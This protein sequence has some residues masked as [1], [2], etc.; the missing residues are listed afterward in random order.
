M[1]RDQG[2]HRRGRAAR[3]QRELGNFL[4]TGRLPALLGVIGALVLLYGFLFSDD[5]LIAS[6]EVRGV[7]LG[8]SAEVAQVAGA[9]GESIFRIDAGHAAQRIAAL[10]YV[11][12]VTVETKFPD[13]VV[14]AVRERVPVLVWQTD[15]ER[16]LVDGQGFVIGPGQSTTLPTLKVQNGVTE[17]SESHDASI[18]AS[19]LAI[20]DDLGPGLQ[21]LSLTAESGFVAALTNGRTVV[22]GD[23]SETPLKL[24]ILSEV[25]QLQESWSLLDLREP[26]R[27]YYK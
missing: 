9:L 6:V 10:T 3:A 2:V 18:V 5:F 1:R 22:F 14:L 16:L 20:H 26:S 19:A 12:S 24:A 7:Q 8:D 25:E 21:R 11:E 15:V 4:R 27:P 17:S 23:A 13:R